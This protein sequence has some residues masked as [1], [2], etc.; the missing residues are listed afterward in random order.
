VYYKQ[1]GEYFIY[2]AL[3]VDG[4]LLVGYNM[5]VIKEVELQL[6]SKLDMK[7]FSAANLI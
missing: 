7:D 5:E 6:S 2:V 4:M 3:Y 1:V